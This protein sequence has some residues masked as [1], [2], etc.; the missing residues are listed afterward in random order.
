MA[1]S[2]NLNQQKLKEILTN[3]YVS[4][5]EK[6]NIHVSDLIEEIKKQLLIYSK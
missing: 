2:E 6:E 3:I 1:I 4:G 5:M